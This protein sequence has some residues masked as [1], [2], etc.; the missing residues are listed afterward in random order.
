MELFTINEHLKKFDNFSMKDLA[1]SVGVSRT[2][3]YHY[4]S[5]NNPTI[6]I[7]KKISQELKVGIK[8]LFKSKQNEPEIQ[9]FLLMNDFIYHIKNK[10]DFIGVIAKFTELKSDKNKEK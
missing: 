6:K 4:L 5:T 9:G 10:Q 2:N 7:L 3:L 8:D 1:K